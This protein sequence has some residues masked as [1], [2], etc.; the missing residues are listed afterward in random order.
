MRLWDSASGLQIRALAAGAAWVERIAWSPRQDVLA[1]A[2][3]KKLR[4]WNAAG[5]LLR[6]W[7]DHPRALAELRWQPGADVLAST[8][9]GEL[10]LWDVQTAEPVRRFAWKGSMIA[11]AW[12]PDGRYLATGNQDATVHFWLAQ[13]DEDLE[14]AGYPSKVR[15]VAWD[16]SSRYLAT[17]GG[18]GQPRPGLFRR[19]AR[20]VE[21]APARSASGAGHRASL[22]APG[23]A[24]RVGRRGRLAGAV[25]AGQAAQGAIVLPSSRRPSGA[26]VGRRQLR[27]SAD[28]AVEPFT[29][30]W[31]G[32]RRDGQEL[33][34][35]SPCS[36][37]GIFNSA[38]AD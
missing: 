17:G 25:A 11:L 2:A 38:A 5:D 1:S 24:A 6:E 20:W 26:A 8:C 12:S 18:P 28:D 13:G 29:L 15:T 37:E 14:M 21:A 7:P 3:G 16:A 31:P 30:N 32:R 19:R 33:E 9:Y 23:Q 35:C 10:N 36:R 4:L 27:W 34:S 22:S